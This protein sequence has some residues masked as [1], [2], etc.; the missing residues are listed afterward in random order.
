[1]T[2]EGLRRRRPATLADL[3]EAYDRELQCRPTSWRLGP[4]RRSTRWRSST[5]AACGLSVPVVLDV[6][7]WIVRVSLNGSRGGDTFDAYYDLP[8]TV[9]RWVGPGP[10][11]TAP[12][13]G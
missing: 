1:M 5:K 8:L 4:T 6:G 2:V 13:P 3:L 10:R 9:A 7:S 12:P 11:G